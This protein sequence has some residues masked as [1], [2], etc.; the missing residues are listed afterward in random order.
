MRRWIKRV[1][2]GI[3]TVVVLA[4]AVIGIWWLVA[5]RAFLY[6]AIFPDHARLL[7]GEEIPE[8]LD[9][10]PFR[11]DLEFLAAELPRLHVAFEEAFGSERLE[12][13]V[14]ELAAAAGELSSTRRRLELIGLL[15]S[16]RQGTG[17][18]MIIPLQRA[19]DWRF[20]PLATYL[21][22]DG[23]FVTLAADAHRDLVGARIRAIG[24]VPTEA[25]LERLAL[26]VSADNEW[27]RRERLPLLL[28]MAEPLTALGLAAADGTLT[29]ELE[30]VATTT[31]TV[32]PVA[33]A[34]LRGLAWGR[35]A[36]SP[37]ETTWSPADPRPRGRHYTLERRPDPTTLY[38]R[39]NAMRE[40]EAEP[41]EALAERLL[42]MAEEDPVQIF[43]IDLRSNGGGNN[44][45][46]R[47]LLEAISG[48]PVLDRRG[49]LYVLIGRRTF[50][51]AGNFAGGLER[52]TRAL[53]AGEP[54]GF[55]PNHYGDARDVLLPGSKLV[56]RLASRFWQEDLPGVERAAIEPDL[57][58]PLLARHHFEDL[59]PTLDAI[60]RYREAAGFEARRP[61]DPERL[62]AWLGSY[63]VS[64][65]HRLRLA[66]SAGGVQ[67][68]I[69]A[70][71]PFAV[72]DLYGDA[73]VLATDIRD[74]TLEVHPSA[75]P[76][77]DWKGSSFELE[78][79]DAGH[80]LPIEWIEDGRIE[81][82]VDAFRAV[83]GRVRLGSEHELA[84]NAAAYDLLG[85]ERIEEAVLLFTLGTELFPHAANTWDSLG[86]GLR[87]AGRIDAAKRAYRRALALDP[88]F[89]HSRRR[90]EELGGGPPER[91]SS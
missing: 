39:I 51:A 24:G 42:R 33:L 41:F 70:V 28:G 31:A 80:R 14:G 85:E 86:D 21:F 38:L 26:Y 19:L 79:V 37:A 78:P 5:G 71:G 16:G 52:R 47:P 77:L 29:L 36:Q 23:L 62:R 56:A 57:P 84:L 69:D 83:A 48:H 34:S 17:H 87:A 2:L 15:A 11:E 7:E 89:D 40:E 32:E 13:R 76:V 20:Y 74:V 35:L 27:S 22:D 65:H 72:T 54:S 45:L 73:P 63:L 9:A 68:T 3:T 58:L 46:P 4:V 30:G 10:E 44:Q 43:V 60:R 61:A 88:L 82:G 25:A 55:A 67:L 6:G 50:S 53:F 90:L 8:R 91:D 12:R 64:P 81:T 49:T 1:L 59:D 18:T 66:E 75:P